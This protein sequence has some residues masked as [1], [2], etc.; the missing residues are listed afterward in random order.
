MDSDRFDWLSR[1]LATAGSRRRVLGALLA[2]A[3]SSLRVHT[4]SADEDESSG[5]V[6][7][8]SSGGN[9]NRAAVINPSTSDHDRDRD[10]DDGD[11]GKEKDSRTAACATTFCCQCTTDAGDDVGCTVSTSNITDCASECGPL[12]SFEVL[13]ADPDQEFTCV[14]NTCTQNA[15]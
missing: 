11:K 10:D 14:A 4:T 13:V 3:L 9:H 5:T 6:I 15:C 12:N 8:D 2:S 1:T 7:A